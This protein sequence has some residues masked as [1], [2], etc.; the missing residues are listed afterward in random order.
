MKRSDLMSTF[1]SLEN[2]FWSIVYSFKT[3]CKDTSVESLKRNKTYLNKGKGE[4]CFILGNGP[5]LK[6][7]TRLEELSQYTVFTVNQ[8]YRSPIFKEVQPS[9]HVMIDPLFFSLDSKKSEEYDTL[10]RIRQ[11]AANNNIKLILPIESYEYVKKFIGHEDNH[12]Y[13]KGRYSFHE[14]YK[15]GFDMSK[16]LPA[17]NNVNLAAIMCAIYMGFEQIVLLGC[18]MTGLLDS[19]I[20]RS[21]NGNIENFSHVYDY[22]EEEKT[23]MHTV[24]TTTSNEAMLSGFA[25][26]FKDYRLIR[27]YCSSHGIRISNASQKTALDTLPFSNLNTILDNLEAIKC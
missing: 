14:K 19:Y 21:P 25:T 12:I 16:Y 13:I 18:D 22:T 17:V 24:H 26:M 7:E 1:G 4:T 10:K 27:E 9:Y 3:I 20:K 23:R 15:L 11:L 8:L 2:A 6:L 5:S